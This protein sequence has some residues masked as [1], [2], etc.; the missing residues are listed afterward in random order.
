[1]IKLYRYTFAV[2][3]LPRLASNVATIRDALG[4]DVA[5]LVAAKAN[6]YGHG[7]VPVARAVV[8]GGAEALGLASVEEALEIRRAK[9]PLSLLVLGA[10]NA[11]GAV[12]AS[13]ADIAV[14]LSGSPEEIENLPTMPKPLAVH[15][16]LDT[17]MGRLGLRT[18][19]ELIA[20][21]KAV[22]ARPDL[23][24]VGVYTHLASADDPDGRHAQGQIARLEHA[25]ASLTEAGIQVPIVHASNTAGALYHSDWRYQMVRIGIGAYGYSPNS[26]WPL[27]L[28]L[29]PVMHL[30]SVITRVATLDAGETVSYGA[31]FVAP[32]RMRVATVPIGYA[33]GYFRSLSNSGITAVKGVEVPVVGRVCMDQLMIDVTDVEGVDVGDVVTLFGRYS[34]SSWDGGNIA[35]CKEAQ[36]AE[37]IV[38]T[39]CRT[40]RIGEVSLDRVAKLA[41]TISY[42][43]LCAVSPRVVRFYVPL[44]PERRFS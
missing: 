11:D 8:H 35:K 12:A 5:V 41:G 22:V 31:T 17:G 9:S 23:R 21:A 16:K 36:R 7:A 28:P 19:E 37:W 39:F 2:V 1:M 26:E 10:I 38:Q 14:T 18:A 3:D 15:L 27:Q 42:E 20:T 13:M 43:L 29:R 30:Y 40:D 34:P 24:L 4:P 25:L 33:D 6:G 44:T 32:R